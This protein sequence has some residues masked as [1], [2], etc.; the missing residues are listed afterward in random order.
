MLWFNIR[1][2]CMGKCYSEFH[3][4]EQDVD[5]ISVRIRWTL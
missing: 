1:D 4:G 5:I 2:D 3:Q